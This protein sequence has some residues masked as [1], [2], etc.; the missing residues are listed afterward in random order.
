MQILVRRIRIPKMNF[1]GH[2]FQKLQYEQ[3][4]QTDRH[5]RPDTLPAALASNNN[6]S[7]KHDTQH[8]YVADNDIRLL[9]TKLGPQEYWRHRRICSR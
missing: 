8:V 3:D 9:T 2:G 7:N 1:L 4:R 6:D 5:T